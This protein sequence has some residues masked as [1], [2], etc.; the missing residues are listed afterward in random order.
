[1]DKNTAKIL[2]KQVFLFSC[3]CG[4]YYRGPVTKQLSL[5]FETYAEWR[6]ML[7]ALFYLCTGT[8]FWPLLRNL[9]KS[10]AGCWQRIMDVYWRCWLD[11]SIFTWVLLQTWQTIILSTAWWASSSGVQHSTVW[12]M[13]S[14]RKGKKKK[15]KN[16]MVC[17]RNFS[18][19]KKHQKQTLTGVWFKVSVSNCKV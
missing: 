17:L 7:H 9:R 5:H 14:Q 19:H 1:M 10:S 12:E 18:A 8:L 2:D 3:F 11:P 16:A 6:F 4:I 15:R 13:T